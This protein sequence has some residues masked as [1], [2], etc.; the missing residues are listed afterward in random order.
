MAKMLNEIIDA[1]GTTAH[2]TRFDQDRMIAHYVRP[3][4][5]IATFVALDAN[6][7]IGFQALE[8]SD[9]D[10][11]PLPDGWGTI[12]SF[13]RVDAAG[14]GVGRALFKAT[15]L[16]AQQAGLTSIDATIRADNESGLGYYKAM[17]FVDY[18]RLIQVPLSNGTRVD[19]IRKRYDL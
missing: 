2:Q 11:N 6:R 10:T 4:H 18:D 9:P 14:K 8:R 17:G 19:R 12:A 7:L 3:P 5:K 16:A 13:V 15:R 1:G